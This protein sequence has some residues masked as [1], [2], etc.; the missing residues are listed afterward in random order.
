MMQ[1]SVSTAS[2]FPRYMTEDAVD[3]IARLGAG[4]AEIFLCSFSEYDP[5]FARIVNEHLAEN[6]VQAVSVHTLNS[7]FEPQLF[8]RS[9]RQRED[10]RKVFRK[11]LQAGKVMGASLYVFHGPANIK[12]AQHIRCDYPWLG[13]HTDDLCRMAADEG[14]RLTWENVFWAYYREPSFGPRVQENMRETLYYTLDVKQALL[15]GHDVF[16]YLEAMG[17]RLANVHICDIDENRSHVL[18]G[19][20][21]FDWERFADI[22]HKKRYDG[23][24]CLEVYGESYQREEELK[25]NFLSV[26]ELFT[27][28]NTKK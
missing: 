26:R 28:L 11:V 24:I 15:S 12:N 5:A 21:I 18:P 9:S 3:A 13:E 14:I 6:H 2:F 27:R 16:A 25:E 20:G 4:A 22:L 1:M 23:H 19:R 17:D 10:A 8:S 7:Q